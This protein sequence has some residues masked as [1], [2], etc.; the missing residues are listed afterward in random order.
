M[1]RATKTS[2]LSFRGGRGLQ[3]SLAGCLLWGILGC[4]NNLWWEYRDDPYIANVANKGDAEVMR[5][6]NGMNKDDRQMGLRIIAT[7]AG[8]CRR[9]GKLEEAREYEE[10]IVRRYFVE[11]EPE[12]RACIVRICAPAC[13]RGSTRMVKFLLDR[14]AAGEYPGYAALSLAALHPRNAYENIE[15]LTRHPAPEVRL[16]AAEALAVLGDPRGYEA[17]SRVWRGMRK[18]IWPDKVDGVP[19]KDAREGL[20]LRAERAFGKRLEEGDREGRRE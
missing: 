4:Q 5:S 20:E 7:R 18:S 16:Q 13:G 19:L 14:I 10:V 8:E 2:P 15:P 9:L 3:A 11:K 17:V 12:V 6:V 1:N